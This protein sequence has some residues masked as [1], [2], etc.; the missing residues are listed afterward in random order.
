MCPVFPGEMQE[1]Q[2]RRSK[3]QDPEK[4]QTSNPKRALGGPS[5]RLG[6]PSQGAAE[7]CD[8]ALELGSWSLE[9]SALNRTRLP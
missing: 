2:T 9:L 4:L 3:I 8:S 5:L 7:L 1:L 6:E